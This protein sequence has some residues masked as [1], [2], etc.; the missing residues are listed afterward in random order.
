MGKETARDTLVLHPQ[1]LE[2][3]LAHCRR[4]AP[5]EACGWISG[6]REAARLAGGQA[7]AGLGGGEGVVLH[8]QRAHPMRNV[9]PNPVRR[10]EMDPVEQFAVMRRLRQAGE[11]LVAIYHSH[12]ATE[13]VPS[14]TDID[15]AYTKD[16]VYVIV[17]LMDDEP[18]WRGWWLDCDTRRC[19]EV[20][21]LVAA[22]D[23]AGS[24]KDGRGG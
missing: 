16:A 1:V 10:Y 2:D 20:T 13:P 22:G 18:T 4:E 8:G 23:G 14:Q 12:P 17:S 15:L 3:V 5:N 19:E 11:E 24:L 21:V 6:V 7:G 9:H